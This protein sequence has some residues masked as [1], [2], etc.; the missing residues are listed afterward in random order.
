VVAASGARA[1][2]WSA[3]GV[4]F[5][6]TKIR[7]ARIAGSRV[8]EEAL[9]PTPAGDPTMILGA[10]TDAVAAVHRPDLPIGVAV[11]GQIDRGAGVIR[12][13]PNIP[14]LN[15]PLGPSLGDA[16]KVPV[17]VDNDVRMAAAGE[18]TVL[19]E[20]HRLL[21]ALYVGTGIG[22]GVLL[23]GN[24]LAGTHNL[25]AEA[26]HAT[27]QPEGELCACGRRGCFEAYAG[28]R[29]LS[30]RAR[31]LFQQR[32]ADAPPVDAAGVLQMARRGDPAA[33]TVWEEAVE[34]VRTLAWNLTVVFDPD[35]L[36]LGGGLA[37][38]ALE[39]LDA[40]RRHVLDQ[41]WS[42]FPPPDVVPGHPDAAVLGAARTTHAES[43]R[44]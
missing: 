30:R 27:F 42:G 23:E 11:A 43:R 5:G 14:G 4:D 6:G 39:L 36:V 41:V 25:A 44:G 9:R 40:V 13:S 3:V 15:I 24:P 1:M 29:S 28:G 20:R 8:E 2:S 38:G 7:A 37:R 31:R 21:V 19:G 26:G 33:M 34:A 10:V 12:S 32:G 18:W 16:F 17:T 22:A 35:A